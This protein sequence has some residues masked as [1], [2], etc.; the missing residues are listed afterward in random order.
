[1]DGR[2]N[3]TLADSSAADHDGRWWW[4]S[5]KTVKMLLV[6]RLDRGDWVLPGGRPHP[7]EGM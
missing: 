1:M 4:G 6:Q 3:A 5:P 7:H 2:H